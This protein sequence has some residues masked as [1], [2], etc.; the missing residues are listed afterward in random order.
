MG[1]Q[2]AEM[3]AP[4]GSAFEKGLY[5]GYLGLSRDEFA[6]GDYM[7]SDVFASRAM[8]VAGGTAVAPEEVGSRNLP[9]DKV[10]VLT[11]ARG[12]LMAAFDAGGAVKAPD[13]AARAQVMFDC[14]M[15]EQEE[16]FQP[17]DI[18][19]C[20]AD[21]FD[22]LGKLEAALEPKMEK[23]MPPKP[24]VMAPKPKKPEP[25]VVDGIYIIFFD[26]DGTA[27]DAEAQAAVRQAITDY[28]K[29]KPARVSIAAHADTSGS[30]KYNMGLSERRAAVVI[31]ALV[32]GG[33]PRSV[34]TSEAFSEMKP[35]V[36]TGDG[37]RERRNRRVEIIFE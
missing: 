8:S 7:D 15:Q 2:K 29:A 20:R 17:P 6:E 9:A 18:E 26:F 31:D 3:M 11:A 12:R 16:N 28:G 14:W 34:M 19:R 13:H 33:V 4:A 22:A 1:L 35:M 32:A 5:D 24:V 30:E 25:V 21:F 37:K 23:K 36:P 27:L 10:N